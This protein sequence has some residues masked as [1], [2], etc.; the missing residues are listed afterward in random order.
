VPAKRWQNCQ[1]MNCPKM[2]V[3]QKAYMETVGSKIRLVAI[4]VL[5]ACDWLPIQKVDLKIWRS[6]AGIFCMRLNM[7]EIV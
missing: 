1:L 6:V 7:C 2:G 3:M 5:I 4:M